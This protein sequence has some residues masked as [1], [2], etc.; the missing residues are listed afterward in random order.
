MVK[1]FIGTPEQVVYVNFDTGSGELYL[2]SRTT[3]T[4]NTQNIGKFAP[5]P[6]FDATISST[7]SRTELAVLMF[8]WHPQLIEMNATVSVLFC[9]ILS[10]RQRTFGSLCVAVCG[11]RHA[12][13]SFTQESHRDGIGTLTRFTVR[14]LLFGAPCDA[15]VRICLNA[16]LFSCVHVGRSHWRL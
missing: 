12:Y 14:A 1:M 3:C 16:D 4:L 8:L 9:S 10:S 2:F 5:T 7:S 11:W 6:C 15:L 13:R